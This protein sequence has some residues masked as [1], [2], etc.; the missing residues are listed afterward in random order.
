MWPEIIRSWFLKFSWGEFTVHP[1]GA[2][3]IFFLL[4]ELSLPSYVMP[5]SLKKL[6][7]MTV[8]FLN[9]TYGLF[10][11]DLKIIAQDFRC[12]LS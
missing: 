4:K 8:Q 12:Q 5:I 7:G 10:L 11:F 1:D 9:Q 3:I 2:K 6:A